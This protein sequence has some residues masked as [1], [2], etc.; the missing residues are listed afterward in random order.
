MRRRWFVLLALLHAGAAAAADLAD[1]LPQSP[2]LLNIRIGE[3]LAQ[4]ALLVG[5][6]TPALKLV[7][8]TTGALLWS[9]G[10]SR[11]AAQRFAAM[12]EPFSGSVIALDTDNDGL[13]DRV[14]AGD[15]AGRLWRFDLHNGAAAGSWASGGVFADFSNGA[16]RGFRAPPDVSLAAP[17]GV[18]PWF[19]IAVGTAAP[20]HV[21]ADNRF[22][23][24]H[25]RAPFDAWTDAQY[26]GWQPLRE[27]DLQRITAT[28]ERRDELL[29]A[30]WFIELGSGE[31]ITAS[32]TVGG[33]IVLAV[34]ESTTQ[35]AVGCRSA[36]SI[37]TVDPGRGPVSFDARGSW[38]NLLPDVLATDAS[39][40]LSTI[41]DAEAASATCALGGTHITDC[42]I[43]TRPRRTWW[44]RMDA[45]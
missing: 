38:R 21:D 10:A 32:L 1:C 40:T 26:R 8:V 29:H 13:H 34:A 36:F 23:V 24:L 28:G 2:V 22:Y 20:G 44:R 30:G 17:P 16:G 14:Y 27:S 3:S 9:A 15:L 7:D 18:A 4:H 5:G 41:V 6:G 19:D 33:R 25:D 12:T 45:E 11:P 37:A 42:D 43:D 31:V 35:S 39:F